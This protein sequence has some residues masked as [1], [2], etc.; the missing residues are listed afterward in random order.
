MLNAK[1]ALQES[2]VHSFLCGVF[3]RL[4]KRVLERDG[5]LLVF[6]VFGKIN[7]HALNSVVG[8]DGDEAWVFLFHLIS[9]EL[10]RLPHGVL[11]H[12][13]LS[14]FG[15]FKTIV[16]ILKYLGHKCLARI[17]HLLSHSLD[18]ILLDV[19]GSY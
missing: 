18:S 17:L 15:F 7:A 2:C 1:Y 6:R 8:Q 19:D 4:I 11:N 3:P 14:F 12:F 13:L 9:D 10:E 5:N 16:K